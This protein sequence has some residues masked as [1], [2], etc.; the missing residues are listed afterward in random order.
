MSINNS[1]SLSMF[2]PTYDDI[3]K[4]TFF[5]N[6]F[7]RQEFIKE[8]SKDQPMMSSKKGTFTNT[9]KIIQRFLTEFTPYDSLFCFHEMGSGKSCAAIAIAEGLQQY[10]TRHTE[11]TN[12]PDIKGALFIVKNSLLMDNFINEIAYTCT[13]RKYIPENFKDLTSKEKLM[14]IKKL[15]KKFYSFETFDSI[16]KKLKNMSG[17]E[18][19]KQYSNM[20][21]LTD[22]SHNLIVDNQYKSEAPMSSLEEFVD[23][24]ANEQYKQI[25]RLFHYVKGG[26]N[27]IMTGTPMRDKLFH[28]ADLLNLILPAEKQM[29]VG[30]YFMKTF[31]TTSGEL[32]TEELIN[33]PLF[34]SYVRGI[35]SFVKRFRDPTVRAQ[36]MGVPLQGY[37]YENGVI[38]FSTFNH[39]MDAFQQSSFENSFGNENANFFIQSI[40]A[41]LAV[42]PDGSYGEE[43]FKKHIIEKK[44]KIDKHSMSYIFSNK[45]VRRFLNA[46]GPSTESKLSQLSKLSCKYAFVIQH[47]L[48]NPTKL[49]FELFF[50]VT[51]SGLIY[52]SLL[53]EQFGYTRATGNETSQGKRFAILSASVDQSVNRTKRIIE[54]FNSSENVN[55]KHIQLII[56][57]E[58]VS[59]GITLKNGQVCDI[60]EAGW[61]KSRIDQ[62]IARLT[63]IFSHNQLKKIMPSITI[64]IYLHSAFVHGG[65][66]LKLKTSIDNHMYKVAQ[67]KDLIQK[68]LT[69]VLKEN[70]IDCMLVKNQNLLKNAVD[71]SDDCEYQSCEY[72]CVDEEITPVDNSTWQVFWNKE[73]LNEFISLLSQELKTQ[74][75]VSVSFIMTKWTQFTFFEILYLIYRCIDEKIIFYDMLNRPMNLCHDGDDLFIQQDLF[76]IQKLETIYQWDFLYDLFSKQ[77]VLTSENEKVFRQLPLLFQERL[78]ED[79]LNLSKKN[80]TDSDHWAHEAAKWFEKLKLIKSDKDEKVISMVLTEA[81]QMPRCFDGTDWS[82]CG[83]ETKSEIK[84][85][86]EQFDKRAMENGGIFGVVKK[87]VFSIFD[88]SS[89]DKTENVDRRKQSR[90]RVCKTW[91][92][93]DLIRFILFLKIDFPR[94]EE[95]EDEDEDEVSLPPKILQEVKKVGLSKKNIAKASVLNKMKNIELCQLMFDWLEKTDL[96]WHAN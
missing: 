84:E 45:E 14:R 65:D 29:P 72:K 69:R 21:I 68:K 10:H 64:S 54:L 49:R 51:G 20:F 75:R 36:F 91:T 30:E 2:F 57:S 62:G 9:Q 8:A 93:A 70:A 66:V 13:N 1:L 22:E 7:A 39:D 88:G 60:F 38:G 53:L 55:G 67:T 80:A 5:K 25:F 81:Y 86:K 56:G 92:K 42:F 35:V 37:P 50:S 15:I 63:R 41:S 19:N 18:I 6:I 59:E 3:D 12:T 48:E 46:K 32:G 82:I 27:M 40:Q 4:P 89:Q 85:E 77:E 34:Q 47:I 16:S 61:N 95:E 79:I 33:I 71:G 58:S 44:I 26:K 78:I 96:I 74:K 28:I 23:R 90:G 43:G 52:F 11:L 73:N 83:E 31:T 17:Y 24:I 94:Q 76:V 87:N